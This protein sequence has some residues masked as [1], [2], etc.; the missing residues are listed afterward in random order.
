VKLKEGQ[1][2][3]HSKYGWGTVLESDDSKTM[4]YFRN[5]GIKKIVTSESAFTL[6][7]GEAHKKETT[8]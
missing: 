4:V 7:G 6:V 8:V 1:Y 2:V 5:V 3:R